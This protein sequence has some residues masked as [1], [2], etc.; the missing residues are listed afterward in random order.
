[1]EAVRRLRISS[2]AVAKEEERKRETE[3]KN[4]PEI[5]IQFQR[6]CFVLLGFP[7]YITR[8]VR[9]FS[10]DLLYYQ[11]GFTGRERNEYM[12]SGARVAFLLVHA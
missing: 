12:V 7:A 5:C 11:C 9:S 8:D 3:R 2:V 1:M 10:S 4:K 6:D